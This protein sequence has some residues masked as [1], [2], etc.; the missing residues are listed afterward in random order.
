MSLTEKQTF[1]F[2]NLISEMKMIIC[3]C[4]L[5]YTDMAG[6]AP[7]LKGKKKKGDFIQAKLRILAPEGKWILRSHS[8]FQESKAQSCT[9]LRQSIVHRKEVRVFYRKVTKGVQPAKSYKVG[10]G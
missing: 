5:L 3:F 9:F 10:R 4:Y 2:Y 7:F 1:C 6:S 8:A